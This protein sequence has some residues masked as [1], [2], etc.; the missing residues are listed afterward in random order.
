[1]MLGR[2]CK[3][4]SDESKVQSSMAL[5]LRRSWLS[6]SLRSG[7]ASRHFQPAS[8]TTCNFT[9]CSP[10]LLFSLERLAALPCP[11]LCVL[12]FYLRRTAPVVPGNCGLK[13]EPRL[14]QLRSHFIGFPPQIKLSTD[15]TI[16]KGAVCRWPCLRKCPL[17]PSTLT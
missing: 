9:P 15:A 14:I 17:H 13:K 6:S 12:Y 7:R 1:M 4:C 11:R 10:S 3:R 16:V 5:N 8:C 2:H